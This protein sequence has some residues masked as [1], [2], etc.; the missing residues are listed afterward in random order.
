[1]YV[2]IKKYTLP[3]VCIA[4]PILVVV[5]DYGSAGDALSLSPPNS[6]SAGSVGTPASSS[7]GGA[8]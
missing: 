1:M 3:P 4:T 8:R 5:A 6:V 2:Y 7:R